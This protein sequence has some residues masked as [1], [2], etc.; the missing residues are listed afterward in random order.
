[1]GNDTYAPSDWPSFIRCRSSAWVCRYGPWPL[2]F[3]VLKQVSDMAAI[4]EEVLRV[5]R[6]C[7]NAPSH[8]FADGRPMAMP[9]TRIADEAADMAEGTVTHNNGVAARLAAV[10]NRILDSTTRQARP[11]A[12]PDVCSVPP[13]R[14]PVAVVHGK[15]IV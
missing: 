10:L 9:S 1:M 13:G 4:L 5:R 2:D 3:S 7:S 8:A 6:S 15:N 12:R 14:A 11:P